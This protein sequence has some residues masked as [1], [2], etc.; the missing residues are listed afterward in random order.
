MAAPELQRSG[1]IIDTATTLP[2]GSTA[3]RMS[4]CNSSS[5]LAEKQAETYNPACKAAHH[6]TCSAGACRRCSAAAA[7]SFCTRSHK[8]VRAMIHATA[9]TCC[10][11]R[12]I[13]PWR[14]SHQLSPAD[15]IVCSGTFVVAAASARQSS[16]SKLGSR[17]CLLAGQARLQQQSFRTVF[18][19]RCSC[20]CGACCTSRSSWSAGYPHTTITSLSA[21]PM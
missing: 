7:A 14:V 6:A 10:T 12:S 8:H 15:Q 2:A 18:E 4:A 20:N 9:N 1:A 19:P 13:A 17:A 5:T 3:G 11:S 21:E 16:R